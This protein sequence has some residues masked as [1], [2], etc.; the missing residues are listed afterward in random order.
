MLT[1]SLF[2][3]VKQRNNNNRKEIMLN[4]IDT[5]TSPTYFQI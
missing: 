4:G 1:I 5:H 2:S 3:F